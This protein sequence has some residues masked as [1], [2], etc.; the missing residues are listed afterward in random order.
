MKSILFL[1]L[2]T[3]LYHFQT[4]WN[5]HLEWKIKQLN[6]PGN[7]RELRETGSRTFTGS[8][9]LKQA[10]AWELS[11]HLSALLVSSHSR[12]QSPR[13]FLSVA[14]IDSCHRPEGSWALGTRMVSSRTPFRPPC[15]RIEKLEYLLLFCSQN[16]P[17]D[18]IFS[19]VDKNVSKVHIFHDSS[20]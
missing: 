1:Q 14:G 3:L 5:S 20:V 11:N 13:S 19:F 16:A 18:L 8:K 15:S 7:Y 2:I 10:C 17:I 4:F 12:P 9:L 6:G